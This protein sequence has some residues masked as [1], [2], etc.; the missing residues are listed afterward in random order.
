MNQH[1]PVR[2]DGNSDVPYFDPVCFRPISE[3]D[4]RET[5]RLKER[6]LDQL[7]ALQHS[8]DEELGGD[9]EVHQW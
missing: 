5:Q 3:K 1:P 7:E 8:I 2:S 6:V 9:D 4:H